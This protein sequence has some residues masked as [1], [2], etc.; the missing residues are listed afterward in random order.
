VTPESFAARAKAFLSDI[1]TGKTEDPF[2]W[3]VKA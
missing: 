3:V 2:G 1:R